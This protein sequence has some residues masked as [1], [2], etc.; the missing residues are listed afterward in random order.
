MQTRAH[1]TLLRIRDDVI[2]VR[3]LFDKASVSTV[4]ALGV[5]N[6]NSVEEKIN[7]GGRG[8][9]GLRLQ[10]Q[11]ESHSQMDFQSALKHTG[12]VSHTEAQRRL[13]GER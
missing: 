8:Q 12:L 11:S 2:G 7:M 5:G 13:L 9:G 6:S 3:H 1:Q 10:S 4:S